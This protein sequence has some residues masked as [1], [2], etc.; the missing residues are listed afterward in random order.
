[1]PLYI[2]WSL[3]RDEKPEPATVLV[4]EYGESPVK[5]QV[6]VILL[7]RNQASQEAVFQVTDTRGY[8][9][10]ACSKAH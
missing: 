4:N 10:L 7:T 1:M 2:Y 5:N 6:T 3:H 8:L 9:I